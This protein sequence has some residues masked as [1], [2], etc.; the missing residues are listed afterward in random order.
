MTSG[1]PLIVIIL[2]AIVCVAL[3]IALLSWIGYRRKAKQLAEARAEVVNNNALTNTSKDA[4]EAMGGH[5]EDGK[6]NEETNSLS[7]ETSSRFVFERFFQKL[8]V[9]LLGLQQLNLFFFSTIY[10]LQQL[11]QRVCPGDVNETKFD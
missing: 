8:K 2:I 10:L 3:I 7:S 11:Q 4:E 5:A 6:D 9:Y 1:L